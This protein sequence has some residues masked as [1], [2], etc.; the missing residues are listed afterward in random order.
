M[1]KRI[2]EQIRTIKANGYTINDWKIRKGGHIAYDL[3]DPKGRKC[4]L[5]SSFSPSDHRS[6]RNFLALLKRMAK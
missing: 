6:D 3:T 4:V 1:T 5:F 2:F